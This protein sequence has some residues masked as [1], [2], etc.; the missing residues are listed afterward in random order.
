MK[1]RFAFAIFGLAAS[2]Y[3]AT[4]TTWEVNGF[5][6]LL[7]GRLSGLSVSVN[8]SLQLGPSVQFDAALDQPALWSIA[9]APDHGVYVSTGHQGKVFRISADGK[10][11]LVWSSLQPEVFAL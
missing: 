10:S 3:A 8:G 7:K 9:R 4:S 1:I 6:D 5:T 2:T 11:S